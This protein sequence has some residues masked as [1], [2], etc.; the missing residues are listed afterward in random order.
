MT[1]IKHA[2]IRARW[3]LTSLLDWMEYRR[4]RA[5]FAAATSG[6]AIHSIDKPIGHRARHVFQIGQDDNVLTTFQMDQRWKIVTKLYPPEASSTP[7]AFLR[8]TKRTRYLLGS[9]KEVSPTASIPSSTRATRLASLKVSATSA[10]IRCYPVSSP[11]SGGK[12]CFSSLSSL[13]LS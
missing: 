10:Q 6:G 4:S 7:W 9:S 3:T 11:A 2:G 1:V 5:A 13:P 12:P 8:R